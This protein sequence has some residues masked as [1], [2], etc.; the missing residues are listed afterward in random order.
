MACRAISS[1]DPVRRPLTECSG[2]SF[3]LIASN[4]GVGYAL[5]VSYR[6]M[7]MHEV[8]Y[9]D[10][11]GFV[12]LICLTAMSSEKPRFV[13]QDKVRED[14]DT[15]ETV[16]WTQIGGSGRAYWIEK[17]FRYS[18]LPRKYGCAVSKKEIQWFNL[19][20]QDGNC[21]GERFYNSSLQKCQMDEY[22]IGRKRNFVCQKFATNK[23]NC[24]SVGVFFHRTCEL[25]SE[26][27]AETCGSAVLI[28]E[29][30]NVGNSFPLG[31]FV[32]WTIEENIRF[33]F[34]AKTT[35]NNPVYSSVSCFSDSTRS[36]GQRFD[37]EFHI[38]ENVKNVES[39]M[40]AVHEACLNSEI[41]RITVQNGQG[42]NYFLYGIPFTYEV[43][44]DPSEEFI[45]HVM[46]ATSPVKQVKC[47]TN[48][49]F[50]TGLFTVRAWWS[51]DVSG[52]SLE[53]DILDG[54]THESGYYRCNVEVTF[55]ASFPRT[56]ISTLKHK[57]YFLYLKGEKNQMLEPKKPTH[58]KRYRKITGDVEAI[59]DKLME[60]LSLIY[61]IAACIAGAILM[62]IICVCASPKHRP[63]SKVKLV[64]RITRK[65]ELF[66][67]LLKFEHVQTLNWYYIVGTRRKGKRSKSTHQR[68]RH[69]SKKSSS[70]KRKKKK[71]KS[72]KKKEKTDKH[73]EGGKQEKVKG[74]KKH[75]GRKKEEKSKSKTKEEA[76]KKDVK[77]KRKSKTKEKPGK[78][79]A[80]KESK[81]KTKEKPEKKGA[82]K[83]SKDKVKEKPV[84][85]DAKKES[86]DKVKEKPVKK[87]AKKES[88]SK[89]KEKPVKKD[90]KKEGKD[91]A[92]EKPVKKDAKKD[93]RKESPDKNKHKHKEKSSPKK[94]GK[95]QVKNKQPSKK[96]KEE[97]KEKRKSKNVARA[98]ELLDYLQKSGEVTSPK[99]VTLQQVLKSDFFNCVREVY[100]HIYG[101][102]DVQGTAETK[103]VATAKATI[104]AFAAAEGHAHPRIIELVKTEEGLGFNVMGGKEQNSPIYISRIIPGGVADRKSGLRRGDQLININGVNV[105]G[106]SH[107]KAVEL[108]KNATGTVKLI[109][110]YTPKLLEEMERR[111][112]QQRLAAVTRKPQIHSPTLS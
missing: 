100:E 36:T 55:Q 93:K 85:K 58:F 26:A 20:I 76:G 23:E 110:R 69:R 86:K 12:V 87:D 19:K 10:L 17:Y 77:K 104:A 59:L 3:H 54:D 34:F 53:T 94:P 91:K 18:K 40:D 25:M 82:K 101:T 81:S 112:E 15:V 16:E 13:R 67:C 44:F 72:S 97:K 70:K 22:C 73:V 9:H 74:D 79:D 1:T 31:S 7:F 11:M 83:E 56:T 29:F 109:V 35:G 88:K 63:T 75:K 62:S 66:W 80:K 90:A 48:F 47:K 51:F 95:E 96:R 24:G 111:F 78:K 108:L 21:H 68:S 65:R 107:E 8:P 33:S 52:A 41:F 99:L 103:A 102:I 27:C 46:D 32:K 6:D 92:K 37:D 57:A 60:N 30:Q 89:T 2:S 64:N 45:Q 5:S 14:A 84:K 42:E 105:E 71:K 38:Y 98:V 50:K 49:K 4:K 61:T 106:E 43:A 28:T 39:Y